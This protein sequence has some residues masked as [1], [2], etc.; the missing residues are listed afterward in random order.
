ME[1]FAGFVAFAIL[2]LLLCC[3]LWITDAGIFPQG[4][5]TVVA[6][7]MQ[8]ELAV[9]TM[10]LFKNATVVSPNTVTA[11]LTIPTFTGYA[12]QA[13]ATVPA[14]VFDP[15]NSGVSI[16]IPSHTFTATAVTSPGETVYG[17]FLKDT[18]GV[19]IACGNFSTP[20]LIEDIG[21]SVPVQVTLNFQADIM[22]CFSNLA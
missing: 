6:T 9:S 22:Q 17:W 7:A 3:K 21:D 4:G 14:P 18:G 13:L 8:A 12:A 2:A 19:T 16:F 11:D 1:L 5:A 15:V 10:N 20:V